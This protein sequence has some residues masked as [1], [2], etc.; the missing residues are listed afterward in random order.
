M[1]MIPFE[2]RGGSKPAAGICQYNFSTNSTIKNLIPPSPCMNV[3]PRTFLPGSLIYKIRKPK[4]ASS[5]PK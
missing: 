3:T 2:V 5:E 4:V 1:L